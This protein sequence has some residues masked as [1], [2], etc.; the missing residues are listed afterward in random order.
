VTLYPIPLEQRFAADFADMKRRLAVLE[1]Q[2]VQGAG[3]YAAFPCTSS[4]HP[5]TPRVGQEIFETD[6]GATAVWTG[7]AWRYGMQQIGA[8]TVVGS[9][10]PSV[11]IPVP[12]VWPRV[13]VC[14][15]VRSSAA[16]PAE[17][18]YLRFNSDTAN[19]YLWQA[20][21]ANNATVAGTDGGGAT[22]V[23]QIGTVTSGTATAGYFASG[24]FVVEGVTDA[25]NFATVVGSGT[26]Y[27]STTNSWTGTYGGQYVAAGPITSLTLACA[28]GNLVTGSTFSLYGLM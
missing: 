27:A 10:Q 16:N 24:N 4:T 14:W 21:Q 7:S 20:D 17:Q 26:A 19:H 9:P 13:Q 22:N 8:T 25:T 11:V 23:I 28:S 18:L 12:A 2:A 3:A 5:A 1:Q 6:T 15:R